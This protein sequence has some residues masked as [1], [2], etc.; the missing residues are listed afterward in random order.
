LDL[1]ERYR[2]IVDDWDAFQESLNRPLP[3]CI[4]VNQQRISAPELSTI[5]R[6][7]G[8]RMHPLAGVPGAF[9][10]EGISNP[11]KSWPYLAGL[12]HIQEHVSLLPAL[13]LEP[14]PGE[15]IL[16]M[17]AAPGG[18]SLQVASMMA[19]RGT[20]HSN[21]INQGRLIA[22]NH[23][24]QRMGFFN[25]CVTRSDAGSLGKGTGRYHRILVDVPCSCEGT[26]RKNPAVL[27]NEEPWHEQIGAQ[28]ALLRKAVQLCRKGGRI[29][30][31]TCSWAPEENEAVVHAILQEYKGYVKLNPARVKGFKF[32]EG[33]RHWQGE[34]FDDTL[35]QTMRVWPHQNDTGGFFVAVLEKTADAEK[36]AEETVELKSPS[37]LEA[38]TPLLSELLGSL[39]QRF[40]LDHSILSRLT[41]YQGSRNDLYVTTREALPPQ[42]PPPE[43]MGLR[44]VRTHE[45]HPRLSTTAAS[46]LGKKLQKNVVDLNSDQILAYVSHEEQTLLPEQIRSCQ[47]SGPV[48]VRV[49]RHGLGLGWL[50]A[51]DENRSPVLKSEFPQAWFK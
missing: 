5:M 2:D 4:W 13:L 6:E 10:L 50:Q 1:L 28:K 32:S 24:L 49:H 20:L 31:S 38:D 33:L 8:G 11:G 36:W 43:Q 17:C 30:Y 45:K 23:H 9:R 29:V 39:K 37:I 3:L 35:R 18:K 34:T 41:L 16:D 22:L 25:V 26:C 42:T 48:V 14:R 7:L 40:G 15:R 27:E 19:N 21:D 51:K 46:L 44:L 47:G 12:F